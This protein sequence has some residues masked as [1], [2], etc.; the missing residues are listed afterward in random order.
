MKVS[1]LEINYK[2]LKEDQFC[3]D[4]LDMDYIQVVIERKSGILE[5]GPEDISFDLTHHN[6]SVFWPT[7]GGESIDLNPSI[8][9]AGLWSK[10]VKEVTEYFLNNESLK[11]YFFNYLSD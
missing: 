10:V 8:I 5:Y 1:S 2:I 3:S 4:V 7:K 9:A 6:L 11:E